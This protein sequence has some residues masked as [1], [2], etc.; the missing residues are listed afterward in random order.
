MNAL[1]SKASFD[2]TI[3]ETTWS[4]LSY[5]GLALSRIRGKL[6]V[7][8]GGQNVLLM[9]S[10]WRCMLKWFPCIGSK[11]KKDRPAGF[12][13]EGPSEVK[14]MV[15]YILPLIDGNPCPPNDK[16]CSIFSEAPQ[17]CADSHFSGDNIMHY[18]GI[19]G[20]KQR[21]PAVETIY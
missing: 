4:N 3:D 17:L 5:G 18:L 20:L 21:S 13:Q 1:I 2:L 14:Y 10:K 6:G 16:S 11:T 12:G 15:D 9:D 7:T 8:K 19:N